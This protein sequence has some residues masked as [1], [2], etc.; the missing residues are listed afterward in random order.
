MKKISKIILTIM[1]IFLVGGCNKDEEVAKLNAN[2]TGND[3]SLVNNAGAGVN[4]GTLNAL[5]QD[6]RD[7]DGGIYATKKIFDIIAELELDL[8][9]DEELTAVYEERVQK[10][11]SEFTENN[12][13]FVNG[14]FSEELL[15]RDLT[16]KLYDINC[17]DGYGPIYNESGE[18]IE[19]YLVCDYSDYV[20]KVVKSK[21][22]TTLLSE[23][24]IKEVLM[25]NQPSLL[26]NK[27]LRHVEYF[28][29][30]YDS[31]NSDALDFMT[32]AIAKIVSGKTFNDLA[33]DWYA[34]KIAKINEDYAKIGTEDDK[35]FALYYDFAYDGTNYRTVEEGLL[36]KKR[37]VY[38]DKLVHDFII[39]VDCNKSLLPLSPNLLEL[40]LNKDVLTAKT[41]KIGNDYYL[42]SPLVTGT[43]DANDIIV[44]DSAKSQYVF[45]KVRVL[46]EES[47]EGD[48]KLAVEKL[49]YNQV[50]IKNYFTHYLGEYKV[51]IHDEDLHNYLKEKYPTIFAD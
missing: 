16:L 22:M 12:K 46:D 41:F 17:D 35:D 7:Q 40:I 1:M 30:P 23:K 34:T 38:A 4:V 21:V 49:A 10:K 14:V 19:T 42:V 13:Y 20:E 29:L 2:P 51:S 26:T 45:V 11:L 32:A 27:K 33:D 48:I 31:A 3:S 37:E 6:L 8:V 5:Y 15:V 24:Y 28:T 9:N 25:E 36:A 44:F 39:N 50:L 43:P 47:P 18:K